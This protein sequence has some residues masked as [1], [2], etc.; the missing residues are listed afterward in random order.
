MLARYV[1]QFIRK[2]ENLVSDPSNN[3]SIKLSIMA[4]LSERSKNQI[5]VTMRNYGSIATSY[6][7]EYDNGRE[8]D[9]HP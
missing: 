7:K 5:I 6:L 4:S 8:I 1:L 9:V 3:K 2:H